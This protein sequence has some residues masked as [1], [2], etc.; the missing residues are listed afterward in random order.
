MRDQ[1][2]PAERHPLTISDDTVDGARGPGVDA[3]EDRLAFPA[4]AMTGASAAE[5]TTV[6]PVMPTD[7][8]MPL[9]VVDVSVTGEQDL[10][11]FEPETERADVVSQA[12]HRGLEAAVEED[13]S[14]RGGDQVLRDRVA[15]DVVDVADDPVGVEQRFQLRISRGT[16]A[17]PLHAAS[18][19]AD[20]VT[21]RLARARG[22]VRFDAIP[23]VRKA[24]GRVGDQGEVAGA[25]AVDGGE[26]VDEGALPDRLQ[27]GGELELVD[28]A[29][30]E[31]PHLAG[32]D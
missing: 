2:G 27:V 9:H 3:V 26:L 32:H 25:L 10:H 30:V 1:R 13:V 20:T 15:A 14:L 19:R 7:Q 8:R 24:S 21:Q 23:F 31:G 22:P 16:P 11:V 18:A 28:V 12:R 4:A 6:A 5:T 29:L 17:I